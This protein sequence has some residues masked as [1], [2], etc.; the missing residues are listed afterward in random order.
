[1]DTSG[2]PLRKLMNYSGLQFFHSQDGLGDVSH[3]ECHYRVAVRGVES[4][5][6]FMQ[7][8]SYLLRHLKWGEVK[9]HGL[10]ES[11]P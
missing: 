8:F 5:W 10:I 6:N 7:H 3:T 2:L 11:I 4:L 9:I 1:M